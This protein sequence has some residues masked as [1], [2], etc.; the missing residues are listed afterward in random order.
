[1]R[2]LAAQIDPPAAAVLAGD[3]NLAPGIIRATTCLV[4]LLLKCLLC[5]GSPLYQFLRTG[6]LDCLSVDRRYLSGQVENGGGATRRN[7][8]SH[9][10]HRRQ[11]EQWQSQSPGASSLGEFQVC[12][13]SR[14]NALR[15]HVVGERGA[16]GRNPG[17]CGCGFLWNLVYCNDRFLSTARTNAACGLAARHSLACPAL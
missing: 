6:E 5:P 11:E 12:H 15:P 8:N 4:H 10:Y 16:V 17:V 13:S 1:M 3:L 7:S 2:Q 9:Q 14:A